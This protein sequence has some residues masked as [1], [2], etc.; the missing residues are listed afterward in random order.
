MNHHDEDKG[1]VKLA[2]LVREMRENLAAHIEIAQLSA[3]ISRAKYLAL[4]A[5]GFT[6]Q[7][8]LELCK[9]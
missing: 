3:K 7:Q 5:E 8:A 9:P 1:R 2:V 4:V 6:E